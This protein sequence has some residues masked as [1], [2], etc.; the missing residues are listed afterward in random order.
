MQPTCGMTSA[1]LIFLEMF[2]SKAGR[3]RVCR[4]SKEN[5]DWG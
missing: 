4:T 2:Y 1:R 5:T 3:E